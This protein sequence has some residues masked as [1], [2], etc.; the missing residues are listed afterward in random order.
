MCSDQGKEKY[1]GAL[2]N[3]CGRNLTTKGAKHVDKHEAG[4]NKGKS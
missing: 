1:E 3:T 4:P 2:S